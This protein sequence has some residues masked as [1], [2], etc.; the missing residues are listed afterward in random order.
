MFL[1]ISEDD[2]F[3]TLEQLIVHCSTNIQK[4]KYYFYGHHCFNYVLGFFAFFYLRFTRKAD[5]Y[6]S[7]PKPKYE[8]RS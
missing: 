7:N 1:F 4:G 2:K 5:V 3:K 6:L 8:L